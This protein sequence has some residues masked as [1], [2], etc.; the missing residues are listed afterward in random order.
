MGRYILARL[1]SLVAS[2]AVASL[3]IFGLIEVIPGD[4]A[5]FMLGLN[6]APEAVAALRAELGLTGSAVSRYFGWVGGLFVGDFGMSYTYR[7]PVG[8]LVA[9]RL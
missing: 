6:A 4:P 3:V 1:V 2:L 8:E 7:V 9:D 5:A